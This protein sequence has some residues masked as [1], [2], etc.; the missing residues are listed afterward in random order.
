MADK[1]IMGMPCHADG[2][3]ATPPDPWW[4][5]LLSRIMAKEALSKA[6]GAPETSYAPTAPQGNTDYVRKA[7]EEAGRRMEEE[8]AKSKYGEYGR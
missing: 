2:V 1:R 5:Q 7:A 8:K 3:V 4:K 6:S